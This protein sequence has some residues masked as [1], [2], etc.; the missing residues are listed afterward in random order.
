MK[1]SQHYT[2]QVA[3][4]VVGTRIETIPPEVAAAA[5]TAILDCLTAAARSLQAAPGRNILVLIT[6]GYDEN[7]AITIQD[8]MNAIKASKVTVY[9]IAIG[10]VAGISL[11]G[12]SVLRAVAAATGGRAFFP[13]REFQLGDMHGLIGIRID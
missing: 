12:E 5:K 6:D 13:S 7:S 3:R 1:I 11:R 9:V 2:E 8:A 4:F 10:G